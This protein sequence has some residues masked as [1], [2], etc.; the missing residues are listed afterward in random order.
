[1]HNNR[2]LWIAVHPSPDI[3]G[4]PMAGP[5]LATELVNNGLAVRYAVALLTLGQ[6]AVLRMA[7]GTGQLSVSGIAG[8]QGL[9]FLGMTTATD[10]F[11]C[12]WREGHV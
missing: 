4:G 8:H 11:R 6:I 7:E 5:A 9:I 3:M 10:L 1:M 12:C 2:G